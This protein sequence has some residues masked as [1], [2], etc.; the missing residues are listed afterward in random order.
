MRPCSGAITSVYGQRWGRMH[1]GIDLCGRHG[2]TVVA[3]ADGV[4]ILAGRGLSGY[5]NQVQIRH[6]D[7]SV[8][9]YSHLSAFL[10][11]GG[12]VSAGTPIG[13]TGSTGNVTGPHLHFEITVGGSHVD[14]Q[15]YLR[16]KGVSI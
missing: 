8:S 7:G 4:V 15:S 14:P 9:S 3:V 1:R 13:R 5:G 2:I 16:R 12:R 6:T 11:R 10:V